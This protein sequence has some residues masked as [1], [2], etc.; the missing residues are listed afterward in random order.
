MSRI[1]LVHLGGSFNLDRK[2]AS[3]KRLH[4]FLEALG[5]EDKP[6]DV[7]DPRDVHGW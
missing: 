1:D 2:Q 4:Q 5:G 7:A 6:S 3:P